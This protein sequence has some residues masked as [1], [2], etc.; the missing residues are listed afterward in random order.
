M[1]K[2]V[3]FD[4]VKLEVC[5]NR[6]IS[7]ASEQAAA[8][9]NSSFSA[10]LGEME[11]LSAGVFDAAGVM[12]AQSVQGAPGHLGSLSAGVKSFLEKFSEKSLKPGDVLITNDP[13][14]VSGHKHD[15]TV[16]T[17]VFLGKR[18]VAFTASNCHT[19]DIGGRIFSAGATE[20][21]EEG[22]NI[23]RMKLF[24]AGR[25][26]ETLFHIIEENVRSPELV[27]GDLMAQVSA[28]ETA[29]RRI[30][31][32]M[33]EQDLRALDALSEAI[34]SRTARLMR[35]A[36]RKLPDGVYRDKASLD[37][38]D[39]PLEICAAVEV[40]GERITVDFA[41]SSPQVP[42]GINS[43]LNF[44]E[45]FTRYA[46]KCLLA[47]E[48][49]NNDGSFAPLHVKAPEASIVNARY[50]APVGGRHLVGLYIPGIIFGA[51][52]GIAPGRVVADS[53]VLSAVTF[54]GRDT[55]DKAYVFTFFSSGGMGGRNGKHGLDATAFPSN[56]ANAPVEVMEQA[57]PL[58]ITRRELIAGSAGRG[59]YRGGAGQ[60]IGVRLRGKH[61]ANVSCMVERTEAAPRGLLGGGPGR[62]AAVLIDGKRVDPK[63][64]FVLQPG[65]ELVLETPGG[66]G[67]GKEAK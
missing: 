23:P 52:A 25:R 28:N 13:W 51:L 34:T 56:V 44:T 6:L 16:V 18:L 15:I 63:Q 1:K 31:D 38:F 33:A 67:F 62:A 48:S 41:G 58:L 53:S 40:K 8:M 3:Q 4:P 26:N 42:K 65:Q 22:L 66:G 24:D 47:P 19:V 11:D 61:P 5:W 36:I 35:Q 20:V 27:L 45:A 30:A 49:P 46:L 21:Y 37:G 39:T 60:R 54:S 55:R 2:A 7:I 12:M 64:A 59:R 29:A 43:V 17:P 14:L 50:P 9:V 10:V 57:T 32:F